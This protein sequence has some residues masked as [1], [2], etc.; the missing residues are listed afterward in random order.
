MGPRDGLRINRGACS[1]ATPD[2]VARTRIACEQLVRSPAHG[3][4]VV[5]RLRGG[6]LSDDDP[7]S[8]LAGYM[9][10]Q[11]ILLLGAA[12]VTTRLWRPRRAR[13]RLFARVQGLK[14]S[15]V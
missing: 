7:G 3:R 1:T 15:G 10:I 11:R 14:G 5:P 4:H 13:S 9:W 6:F 8:T 2:G 12:W